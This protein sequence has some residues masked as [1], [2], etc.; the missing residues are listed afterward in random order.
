MVSR[1]GADY[2]L[3]WTTMVKFFSD[4]TVDFIVHRGGF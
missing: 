4:E 2:S 1:V 3:L